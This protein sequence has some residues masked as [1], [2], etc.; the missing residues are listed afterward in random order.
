MDLL[1]GEEPWVDVD[2]AC[3][4][5]YMHAMRLKQGRETKKAGRNHQRE[6]KTH[7]IKH[8][9]LHHQK[10]K[11]TATDEDYVGVYGDYAY[12]NATVFVNDTNGLLSLNSG[13]AE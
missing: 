13:A 4:A 8:H 7:R 11:K 6:S 1:L 5:D 9:K 12:G 10:H 2:M 3:E